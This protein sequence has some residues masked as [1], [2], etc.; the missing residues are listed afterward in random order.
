MGFIFLLYRR[1]FRPVFL[2]VLVLDVYRDY[3]L[4]LIL[5]F[6]LRD[7]IRLYFDGAV[8]MVA[9]FGRYIYL[10]KRLLSVF[11]DGECLD[12]FV[13]QP[14]IHHFDVIKGVAFKDLQTQ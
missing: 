4:V 7:V 13:Q 9:S 5:S 8:F 3:L 2:F 6:W 12:A 11:Y 10:S 1:S 14:F